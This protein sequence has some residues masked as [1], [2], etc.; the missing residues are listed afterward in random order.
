MLPGSQVDVMFINEARRRRLGDPDHPAGHAGAGRGHEHGP[1]RRQADAM[2]GSTVTLAATPEEAEQL[3]LAAALGELRLLLRTPLD[4]PGN[5][6]YK[7]VT[8]GGPG[9]QPTRRAIQRAGRDGHRHGSGGT[10]GALPAAEGGRRRPRRRRRRSPSR[11]R[12]RRRPKTH[13]HDDRQRRRRCSKTVFS[14]TPTTTAGRATTRSARPT[15]HRVRRRDDAAEAKDAARPED[16]RRRRRPPAAAGQG[17]ARG[18]SCRGKAA[19]GRREPAGTAPSRMRRLHQP[20]HAGRS[21]D[22]SSF[23]RG[24]EPL[25]TTGG[26]AAVRHLRRGERMHRTLCRPRALLLGGLLLALLAER[27]AAGP[28]GPDPRSTGTAAH[29]AHRRRPVRLQMTHEEAD[30]A[31][32]PTPRRTSSTSARCTAIR[33]PS[34]LTGQQPGVTPPRADRRGR[35]EGDLRGHRPGG[36]RVPAQRS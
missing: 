30:Q 5:V 26:D 13:T 1:R 9:P 10:A 22:T 8:I 27:T 36:H 11:R 31:R 14:G 7:P 17:C 23:R 21:P 4:G 19:S 24:Q 29:R 35:Q 34:L 20:A 12:R 32:S 16:A 2:L 33:P 15:R 28:P 25:S 18:L 3:S 6:N